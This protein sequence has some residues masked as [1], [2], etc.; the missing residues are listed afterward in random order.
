M[1]GSFS[2]ASFSRTEERDGGWGFGQF[3]GSATPEQA[4]VLRTWIPSAIVGG[5][6]SGNYP[7]RVENCPVNPQVCVATCGRFTV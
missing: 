5:P 7:S 2:Y 1:A 4:A 6:V 3:T